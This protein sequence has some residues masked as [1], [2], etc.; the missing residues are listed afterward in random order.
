MPNIYYYGYQVMTEALAGLDGAYK[1]KY[2][3][4]RSLTDQEYNQL[5]DVSIAFS[6]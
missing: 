1:G 4:L 5:I 3:S 2:Y 6:I